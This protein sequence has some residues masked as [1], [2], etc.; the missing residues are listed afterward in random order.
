[1][2]LNS[3]DASYSD[4]NGYLPPVELRNSD[5]VNKPGAMSPNDLA[6]SK[7]KT[8]SNVKSESIV[9]ENETELLPD[10]MS[11]DRSGGFQ[12]NGNLSEANR[13]KHNG[14]V[15]SNSLN[16]PNGLND[17]VSFHKSHRSNLDNGNSCRGTAVRNSDN[18]N[19]AKTDF[20][21]PNAI[22]KKS[23]NPQGYIQ[24]PLVADSNC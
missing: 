20:S 16:N 7:Q 8:D 22:V 10:T 1:M 13:Q 3:S 4:C 5:A 2:N 23:A 21:Q 18:N 6:D 11:H 12:D 15:Q 17:N 14:Y 24:Y 9:N 19:V